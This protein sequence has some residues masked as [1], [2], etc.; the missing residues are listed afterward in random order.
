MTIQAFRNE[1]PQ[2][3]D[4]DARTAYYYLE[5]CCPKAGKSKCFRD[6]AVSSIDENG[7]MLK[8]PVVLANELAASHQASTA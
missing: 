4:Q 3:S 6:L 7:N 1:F 8:S 5:I 2:L